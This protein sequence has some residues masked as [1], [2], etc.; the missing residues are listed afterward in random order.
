MLDPTRRNCGSK[1]EVDNTHTH[2]FVFLIVVNAVVCQPETEADSESMSHE[3]TLSHLMWRYKNSY[4]S[5]RWM[6]QTSIIN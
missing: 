6:R 1:Q 3:P 2:T 5:F 4:D